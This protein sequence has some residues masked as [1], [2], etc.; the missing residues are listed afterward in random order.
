MI[1]LSTTQGRFLLYLQLQAFVSLSPWIKLARAS[2]SKMNRNDKTE[3]F[4]LILKLRGKHSFRHHLEGF[5]ATERLEECLEQDFFFW[6]LCL[7]RSAPAAHGGSQARDQIGA[8]LPAYTAAISMEDLSCVFD[9]YLQAHGNAGSLMPGV[10]PGIEPTTSW[11]LV[12]VV[13]H[14]ARTGTP[15]ARCF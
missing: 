11:F 12:G 3:H 14:C 5:V 13:N 6:S 4:P 1:G 8:E 10:R 2:S 9:L 15:R 7:F